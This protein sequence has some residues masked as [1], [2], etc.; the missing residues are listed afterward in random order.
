LKQTVSLNSAKLPRMIGSL[1]HTNQFMKSFSLISLTLCLASLVVLMLVC[2]RPP[3]V[4]TLNSQG[5]VLA[6]AELPKVEDQLREGIKA[7]LEKRYNWSP[8]NA[9][10]QLRKAEE[11]ILP[12]TLKTFQADVSNVARFSIQKNVAQKTYVKD[13]KFDMSQKKVMVTGDR[14]TSIQGLK[15]AGDLKVEL[16]FDFG[17]RTQTNPWGLYITKERE[18]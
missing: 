11:F 17:P 18:G 6:Q 10:A 12:T 7:Y 8:Q 13:I 9:I 16:S 5:G 4:I 2:T 1:M 14:F 3:I 15:A